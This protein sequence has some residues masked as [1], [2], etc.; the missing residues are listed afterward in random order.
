MPPLKNP[1]QAISRWPGQADTTYALTPDRKQMFYQSNSPKNSIAA[2]TASERGKL[3]VVMPVIPELPWLKKGPIPPG[4]KVIRN[5]NQS[6]IADNATEVI[7]DTGEI[8]RNWSKGIYTINTPRTQAAM[9]WIGNEL[10]DLPDVIIY[11]RTRNAS[12]AVQSLDGAPIKT[13]SSLMIS[14]SAQA[15]PTGNALPFRS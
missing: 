14:L 13:S 1:V 3:V 15:L 9:G 10:I 5:L 11:I 12:V 8:S 6:M 7:S 2:R 4:A